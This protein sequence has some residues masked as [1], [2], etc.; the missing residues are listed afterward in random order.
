M[1]IKQKR[2]EL[3]DDFDDGPDLVA[4]T[5]CWGCGK[6]F[7]AEHLYGETALCWACSK[8]LQ[9]P[10]EPPPRY[11]ETYHEGLAWLASLE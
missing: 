9:G 10:A 3:A 11:D 6:L 1:G 8:I 5:L 7:A 2:H 4:D